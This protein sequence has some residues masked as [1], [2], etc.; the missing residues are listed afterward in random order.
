MPKKA[1]TTSE[2]PEDKMGGYAFAHVITGIKPNTIYAL[3]HQ[4]RIPHYRL[5]RRFVVFKESELKEW[6]EAHRVVVVAAR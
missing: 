6:M 3:V 2:T 5:G 1:T 4:G